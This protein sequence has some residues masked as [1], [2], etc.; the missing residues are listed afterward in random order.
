MKRS[1]L[2]RKTPLRR[3]GFARPKWS[4]EIVTIDGRKLATIHRPTERVLQALG[5][6]GD[7]V[8]SR[9]ARRV[10]ARPIPTGRKRKSKYAR[11]PR[12]LAYMQWV[13]TLPCWF[14]GLA[15]SRIEI[16]DAIGMAYSVPAPV[17]RCDGPIEADHAGDRP[18]GIKAHDRTCIP[19]CRKHH[20]DRTDYRG[21]F[22]DL[23]GEQMRAWCNTAIEMT[24]NLARWH[25]VEVPEC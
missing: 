3:T 10:F 25:G 18:L 12:A 7:S 20:R 16:D 2:K 23:S 24:Q 17:T 22:S 5:F 1:P 15:I 13:K 21:Y 6:D 8:A 9:E 14:Y 11:R 4:A 19:L